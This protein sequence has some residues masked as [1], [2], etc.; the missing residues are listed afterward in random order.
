M[1]TIKQSIQFVKNI[2]P[3]YNLIIV[4]LHPSP[5]TTEWQLV[6]ITVFKD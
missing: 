3:D 5:G 4:T 6:F 2:M 1:N